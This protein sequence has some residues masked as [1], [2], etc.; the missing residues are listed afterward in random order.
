MR[1]RVIVVLALLLIF[2]N[3]LPSAAQYF[4]RNKVQYERI[5]P[6]TPR[7]ALAV[8]ADAGILIID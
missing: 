2:G 3:A 4:G 7:L 1:S 6:L 5:T 8:W